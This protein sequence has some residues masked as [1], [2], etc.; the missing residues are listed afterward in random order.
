MGDTWTHNDDQLHFN[1]SFKNALDWLTDSYVAAISS[2]S[3]VTLY[4]MDQNL[5]SGRTYAMRIPTGFT[6]GS[7]SNLDYWIEARSRFP[8]V[9]SVENGVLIYVND[10]VSSDEALKLLDM[11]PATS[12]VVDAGLRVGNSFTTKDSKWKIT[13]DSVSGSGTERSFSISIDDARLPAIT[14]QPANLS[15]RVDNDGTFSVMAT[16]P[17]LLYQWYKDSVAITGATS[18]SYTIVKA[19]RSDEGRYYVTITNSN[20]STTSNSVT[21]T[22]DESTGG[23]GGCG[24][25]PFVNL[26][27]ITWGGFV[28]FKI[29][30]LISIA[31]GKRR[32]QPNNLME[33]CKP[34]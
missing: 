19:A 24:S 5:V 1:A 6:L 12:S 33:D 17:S 16:G 28:L 26:L 29:L 21:F 22:I 7:N 15:V 34:A 30:S 32:H 31:Q 3:T 25:I 4:A 27:A 14:A 8:S 20:G 13:V 23:G 11:A 18:S 10:S 2:P 9:T